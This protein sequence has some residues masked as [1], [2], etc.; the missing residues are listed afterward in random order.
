MLD[1]IKQAGKNIGR[2]LNRAWENLSDG[3]RELLSRSNNSLTH[4]EPGMMDGQ[5]ESEANLNFPRWGL[6][7]CEVEETAS[8]IIVRVEVPGVEKQDCTIRIEGSML[9]LTGEKRF[10][11]EGADS[12]YHAM[13]RAYGVFERRIAL[14]RHVNAEK[15]TA[16]AVN[17]VLLIRLPKA[18]IDTVRDI[19]IS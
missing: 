7:A 11:R 2:E 9:T 17:G 1:S 15:A 16:N 13:E 4:F 12:H 18:A 10:A 3:W 19:P 5:L 6:I 8:D 14:P